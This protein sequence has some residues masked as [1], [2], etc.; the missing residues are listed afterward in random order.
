VIFF[1]YLWKPYEIITAA[2]CNRALAYNSHYKVHLNRVTKTANLASLAACNGT[3]TPA[4]YINITTDTYFISAQSG[5][6]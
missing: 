1:V 4:L 5:T 3:K 6:T 2:N